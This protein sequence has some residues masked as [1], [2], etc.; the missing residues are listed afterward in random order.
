MTMAT[1]TADFTPPQRSHHQMT[2]DKSS[3]TAKESTNAN[4]RTRGCENECS[5]SPEVL[6]KIP[7]SNIYDTD[8]NAADD[9]LDNDD[10]HHPH[11]KACDDFS[12][13]LR[14]WNDFC[15]EFVQSTTYTLAQS[16][17]DRRMSSPIANDD[18]GTKCVNDDNTMS[19]R[20]E[21]QSPPPTSFDASLIQVQHS[22][23]VLEQAN[24][25]FCQLLERLEVPAPCQPI[26]QQPTNLPQPQPCPDP[27]RDHPPQHAPTPT[28]PP[29]PNPP[30][31]PLQPM[32]P[33]QTHGKQLPAYCPTPTTVSCKLPRPHPTT[34][35]S[36]PNWAKP[37]IPPTSNLVADMFCAGKTLW[38]PPRP[39]RKTT[40]FKKKSQTKPKTVTCKTEKDSLRP[41]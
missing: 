32:E 13:F 30:A 35:T 25:Q 11:E 18:D 34:Q 17:A 16:S 38:P 22:V 23:R 5:H 31:S 4:S 27:Q 21:N 1:S 33:C 15:K 12:T 3:F 26:P 37:A 2:I 9:F 10:D 19:K 7:T 20:S 40:P 28:M 36:I 24:L 6:R 14:D 41:P 8:A 39:E 29:A